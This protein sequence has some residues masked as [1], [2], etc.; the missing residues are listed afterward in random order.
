MTRVPDRGD[1]VT[2][3]QLLLAYLER[4]RNDLVDVAHG[5]QDALAEVPAASIK[6][7]RS[8]TF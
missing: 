7:T 6:Q 4:G 2:E 5:C 3:A 8:N 1:S